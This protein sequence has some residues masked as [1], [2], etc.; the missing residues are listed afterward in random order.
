MTVGKKLIYK[1]I[2]KEAGEINKRECIIVCVISLVFAF[3][4]KALLLNKLF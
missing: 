1:L 4:I 2:R 3:I